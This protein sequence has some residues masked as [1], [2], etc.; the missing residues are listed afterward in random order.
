MRERQKAGKEIWWYSYT[1]DSVRKTPS[2]VIDKPHIDSRAWGWLSEQWGVDGILNWGFNAW[3][4]TATGKHWRDPY[5][6]P[7]SLVKGHT[8]SNGD[9]CLVYPGYYPP[10]G[11]DDPYA[12]PVSSL[13][14]EALRDGLE[15]R[16]YLRAAEAQGAEG[17]ALA[18]RELNTIT[19]FPYK[20]RQAN[21]FDF[22]KYTSSNEVFDAA[23]EA[24]AAF[25]EAHP[26]Q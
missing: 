19:Q 3:S 12:A 11:L 23:R 20:I 21:V 16:E 17:R 10:Y 26:T 18:A 14:L 22:P 2:F 15:E 7:L 9:T 25:I 1:N 8:R 6:D 5:Q 4:D 13:R 24:L